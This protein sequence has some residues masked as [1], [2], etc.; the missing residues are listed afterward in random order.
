M[1]ATNFVLRAFEESGLHKTAHLHTK[2]L[3]QKRSGSKIM[4]NESNIR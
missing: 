3:A 2:C 4:T 1:Y